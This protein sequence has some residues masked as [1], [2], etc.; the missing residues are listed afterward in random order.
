MTL[1]VT[2]STCAFGAGVSAKTSGVRASQAEASHAGETLSVLPRPD[3]VNILRTL[4]PFVIT[5][6]QRIKPRGARGACLRGADLLQ[7]LVRELIRLLVRGGFTCARG[8]IANKQGS[9][10]ISGLIKAR[11]GLDAEIQY[12]VDLP[13][14]SVT[15]GVRQ[16]QAWQQ[17]CQTRANQDG[18]L[19]SFIIHVSSERLLPVLVITSSDLPA[20]VKF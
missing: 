8:C 10:R 15:G 6:L 12:R 7:G 17:R 9:F 2:P 13:H 11:T 20:Q 14:G 16:C 18:G 1:S 3:R 19:Q 4:A 5:R